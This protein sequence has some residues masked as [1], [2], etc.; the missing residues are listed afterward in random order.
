[1][2]KLKEGDYMGDLGIY[3]RIILE[4]I[5]VKQAVKM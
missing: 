4:W 1:L 3:G 2:G 5:L